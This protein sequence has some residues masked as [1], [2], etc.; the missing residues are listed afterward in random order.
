[1]SYDARDNTWEAAHDKT[2]QRGRDKVGRG[3]VRTG[4]AGHTPAAWIG[5]AVILTGCVV[6]AVALPMAQAW[7]FWLGVGIAALGAVLGKILSLMGL[8]IP[9][10]YHQ[11]GD[12]ELRDQMLGEDGSGQWSGHQS[13]PRART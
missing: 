4:N 9:P 13:S 12:V 10:G 1:M 7:L 8:G 6:A 2:V 3:D 11:E 5:V